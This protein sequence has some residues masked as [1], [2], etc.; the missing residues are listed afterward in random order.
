MQITE[1]LNL[2]INQK[3]SL[4]IYTCRLPFV[5]LRDNEKECINRLIERYN[6]QFSDNQIS[7]EEGNISVSQSY[8]MNKRP[9]FDWVLT[10]ACDISA[11]AESLRLMLM[12]EYN[13]GI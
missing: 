8:V 13:N 9:N 3:D 4:W 2:R 11:K 12:E 10:T 6:K 5:N 7:Y 1:N